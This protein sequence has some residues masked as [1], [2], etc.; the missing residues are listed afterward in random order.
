MQ[1]CDL[2][3][4]GLGVMGENLALNFAR[5]GFS[6]CG[7]DLDGV[8]RAQFAERTRGQRAM[9]A[10]DLPALLAQ[11]ARP[12]RILMMVPAGA[13]VDAVIEGLAGALASGDV[14]IDGGNTHPLD[15]R[16]RLQALQSRGVHYVG[17]GV[18]GGEQGAL[19]GPALM[20]GGDARAWPLIQPMLQAIAAR[21]ADG[22]PCCDWIGPDGAGH[23]VKMAHN[24]IEYADMQIL[25][26]AYALMQSLGMGAAEIA[27]VFRRW[28]EG[29]L[30]SYLVQITADILARE[31]PD[32]GLAL[33]DSILD[34]AEQKGTGKWTS[35]IA[36]DIGTPVPTIA[37]AVSARA[38][39]ALRNERLQAATV[40]SGARTPPAADR[41]RVITQL[42]G[43]VLAARICAYAQGMSLLRAADTEYRWGLS[44][45]GVASVWRAGCIIRARLLEDIRQAFAGAPDLANLLV[46]PAIARRMGPLQQDLR[47]TVAFGALHGVA[48]PALM[49][50]LA[51]HD[52]YRSQRLPA[53]LMQAQRDCFGAHGY[54]RIDRPGTFHTEWR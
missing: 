7:F 31:D 21:A 54:Q 32:S 47:E 6:V 52:A 41:A 37:Q 5:N 33:V 14:L 30:E 4:I 3:L 24:G 20:P 18:S 17:M 2:G 15:T 29:A 12:R 49:S 16:R 19:R 34:T 43:A 26:E 11:L 8:K 45:S 42:E 9:V 38:I 27:P 23:F 10:P 48:M 46:D 22:V 53:N 35:Q 44:L 25:C 51:Y 39:S 13:A 50:A 40:L 28:N 1:H 36:L